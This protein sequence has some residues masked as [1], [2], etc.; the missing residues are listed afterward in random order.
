MRWTR[1]DI[2]KLAGSVALAGI[3]APAIAAAPARIVVVGGGPA[4]AT[5][6]R[7]LARAPSRFQVTMVEAEPRYHTCF[8]SNLYLAGLRSL[9]SLEHSYEMLQA[10]HGV[11]IVHDTAIAIEPAVKQVRLASSG[12]LQYDRLVVAPGIAF[13][14]DAI[15][16][17]DEAASETLPHAWRGAAQMRLLQRQ[18][19][20]MED[21]GLFLLTVP[22]DPIRCPPGPYE[23]V[24]LVACYLKREK[25]K[26]KI[27]VLDSKN[28]FPKQELFQDAWNRLYRGMVEWLPLDFHG[29]VTSVDAGTRTVTISNDKF[30]C[31][32]A[33]VIPPHTAGTIA[34][35]TDLADEKGWCPVDPATLESKLVP[36]I[37]VVG[38][39][40][41][42]GE[43]PKSAFA[44]NSQ[45][46]VCA[47]AVAALL[48]GRD[49][50]EAHYFNTCWSFLGP[51]DAV[52]IGASYRAIDGKIKAVEKFIS[53]VEESAETRRLAAR[54][55]EA[56]Y[57]AI[58]A[59]AFG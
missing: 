14:W 48:D 31:A 2:A 58:T 41:I 17:Y 57:A 39:A 29:G 26:S 53:N 4:G 35:R 55:A 51:D 40:I 23:R 52:K 54:Q 3:A 36:R 22:P 21:G 20:A 25:P 18:L 30:Q 43:M 12:R 49:P 27:L 13:R 42:P 32:V 1:R 15:E 24:S 9:D 50:F 56:W 7:Y 33:N 6:A 45:A 34:L 10:K 16:G 5:V 38:D 46:K 37:H 19:G 59:D 8:F 44:A 11:T 28:S 47:M